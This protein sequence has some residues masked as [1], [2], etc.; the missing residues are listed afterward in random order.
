MRLPELAGVMRAKPFSSRNAIGTALRLRQALD[1]AP[2][3]SN[4]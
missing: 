4:L 1:A 3:W 2:A